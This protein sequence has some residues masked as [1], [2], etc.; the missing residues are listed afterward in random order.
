MINGKNKN[1]IYIIEISDSI[2]EIPGKIQSQY[3]VYICIRENIL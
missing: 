2:K 3:S 1:A